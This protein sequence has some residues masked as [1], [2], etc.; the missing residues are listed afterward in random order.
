MREPSFMHEM[1]IASGKQGRTGRRANSRCMEVGVAETIISQAIEGWRTDHA[2]ERAGR[3]ISHI[4]KNNPNDIG[5]PSR[6]LN[7]T[8]PPFFRIG[9]GLADTALVSLLGSLRE[10]LR[11]RQHN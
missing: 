1:T 11:S 3:A 9:Q 8:G 5:S 10:P 4:I 7:R 6:G 2:P